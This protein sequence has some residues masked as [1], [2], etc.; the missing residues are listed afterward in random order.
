VDTTNAAVR[1]Y[2]VWLCILRIGMCALLA[3][4]PLM[5]PTKPA[6]AASAIQL[7]DGTWLVHAQANSSTLYCRDRLVL[8]TNRH[9]QLSGSVGFARASAPIHN[10]VLLPDG[11]F[12]GA[13]RSGV[14]GS[15]LGRFY[16]VTGKFSG[17]EVSVTLEGAGCPPRHG[18]A[19]R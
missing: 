19:S 4:V 7:G 14:A 18:T 6:T 13:T 9:G 2:R 3:A 1:P 16:K 8:L 10:L 5:P 17:E 11:S 15:K 12:S